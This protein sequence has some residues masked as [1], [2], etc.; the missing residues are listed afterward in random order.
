MFTGNVVTQ[1]VTLE[2]WYIPTYQSIYTTSDDG[3]AKDSGLPHL[4]HKEG[5]RRVA[6]TTCN[7]ISISPLNDRVIVGKSCVP[8]TLSIIQW[9]SSGDPVGDVGRHGSHVA[10]V[11]VPRLHVKTE[12]GSGHRA[13]PDGF[14]YAG[15]LAYR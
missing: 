7:P 3:G 13:Y 10:L 15:M 14:T 8:P 2:T 12:E 11:S 6:D 4:P 1:H 5:K 9:G